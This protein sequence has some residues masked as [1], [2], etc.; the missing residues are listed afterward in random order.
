MHA[1]T[2]DEQRRPPRTP[3]SW[4]FFP[5]SQDSARN[6]FSLLDD[7]MVNVRNR[8]GQISLN[9]VSLS[10]PPHPPT[11]PGPPLNPAGPC[12]SGEPVPGLQHALLQLLVHRDLFEGGERASQGVPGQLLH[13]LRSRGGTSAPP[14][15]ASRPPHARWDPPIHPK[16]LWL[17]TDQGDAASGE[18][19][20]ERRGEDGHRTSHPRSGTRGGEEVQQEN[21]R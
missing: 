7:T 14:R 4:W 11:P 21:R 13:A 20:G 8:M 5:L 18:R 1:C 16:H 15:L 17:S 6:P 19:L 3:P 2:H 12:L 10:S 9:F